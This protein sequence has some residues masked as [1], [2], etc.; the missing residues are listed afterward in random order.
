[1]L[2]LGIIIGVIA[3]HVCFAMLELRQLKTT[4]YE[5]Y[6]TKL[7]ELSDSF[8]I[9]VLSDLHCC[10]FGKNNIKLFRSL[11]KTTPDVILISGDLVNGMNESEFEFA[12]SFLSELSKL[13]IPV[14]YTFGNHEE[15]YRKWGNGIFDRYLALVQEY[16]TV[17]NNETVVLPV[18]AKETGN[19]VGFN[20]STSVCTNENTN[21]CTNRNISFSNEVNSASGHVGT[22][23]LT[24]V[25]LPEY[26]YR[27]GDFSSAAAEIAAEAI[28]N[29][30]PS[31]L[32]PEDEHIESANR[33]DFRTPGTV[34][35]MSDLMH[36]NNSTA[37]TDDSEARPA[38]ALVSDLLHRNNS[39][40]NTDDSEARSAVALVSDLLHRNNST[41]NTGDSEAQPAVALVSDLFHLNNPTANT[42]DSEARPAVALDSADSTANNGSY[43]IVI[44][45]DPDYF[46]IL[47][48]AGADMVISG[49]V[50][51]G[52]IR[53]PILGGLVNP[54][55]KLFP[56]FDKGRFEYNNSVMYLSGGLGW[57]NL[58]IRF[59]NRPEIVVISLSNR[60]FL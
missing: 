48:H 58:P 57:H 28:S 3:L 42:G 8:R 30:H 60:S 17:L 29:I 14:Y 45:H 25:D 5:E 40:A 20:V 50:H 54:K 19:T 41:A 12:R 4:Y 22:I 32:L 24:G 33:T 10:S 46:R 31:E 16:V 11:I 44:S 52:I 43:R 7:P 1:M 9:A 55:L 56:K 49:H 2:I 13:N 6:S 47:A 34:A 53:L 27:K 36:R 23:T 15:R 26:M 18:T 38:V 35:L 51:G 37:N 59:M 21:K 39:T